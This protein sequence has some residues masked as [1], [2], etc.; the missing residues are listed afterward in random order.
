MN[1]LSLSD[2]ERMV[3]LEACESRIFGALRRGL[4]ATCDVA[5]E[6]LTIDAGKLYELRG[7]ENLKAYADEELR[8]D[9]KAVSRSIA[10]LEIIE[11]LE[12]AGIELPS[13]E[14]QLIELARLP[15]EQVVPVWEKLISACE[16]KDVPV[17][18]LRV[19]EAVKLDLERPPA[20]APRPGVKVKFADEPEPLSEEG[21]RALARIKRVCG[22]E[23]AGAIDPQSGARPI[24]ER[25]IIRW[26]ELRD[27][28]M[29][30]LVYYVIDQAWSVSEAIN[31]EERA[32]NARSTL[33]EIALRARARGGRLAIQHEE[34]LVTVDKHVA[35]A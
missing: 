29:R 22:E 9:E 3:E 6:L 19:R 17:T 2:N 27:D 30:G 11:R 23:V 5:K 34:F 10:C 32:V 26:A 21:E 35:A 8:L 4:E 24:S 31:Y 28:Q 13:N 7:H 1:Q 33:G 12:N 15:D 16:R 20:A 25:A 14:S 18:V